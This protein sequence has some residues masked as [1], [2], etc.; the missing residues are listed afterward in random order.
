MQ[1]FI[2]SISRHK[3]HQSPDLECFSQLDFEGDP[4]QSPEEM[5]VFAGFLLEFQNKVDD[6]SETG[7]SPF[8]SC[9]IKACWSIHHSP[10]SM[11]ACS[12]S[13]N[14]AMICLVSIFCFFASL[15][16]HHSDRR[17]I[18]HYRKWVF[19]VGIHEMPKEKY[20]PQLRNTHAKTIPGGIQKA[21]AE[22]HFSRRR[23]RRGLIFWATLPPAQLERNA[24]FRKLNWGHAWHGNN[25]GRS[26]NFPDSGDEGGGG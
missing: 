3:Q 22:L 16:A 26:H 19:S 18:H 21:S 10:I 14:E 23:V 15:V 1:T 25:R 7:K 8:K 17:T 13:A 12:T 4:N 2:K 5:I 20:K 11:T 6:G 9:P 24:P